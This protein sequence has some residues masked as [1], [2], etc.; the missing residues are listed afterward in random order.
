MG[1]VTGLFGKLAG[2]LV[3]K[4]VGGFFQAY[5]MWIIIAGL[6]ALLTTITIY[7]HGAEKAKA[8]VPV[9]LEEI[10]EFSEKFAQNE[11][12]MQECLDANQFNALEAKRQAGLVKKSEENVNALKEEMDTRVG[13]IKDEMELQRGRDKECR[14]VDDA[15]PAWF[16]AGLRE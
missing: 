9:L 2:T 10:K 6:V 14:T 3:G 13:D 7:V 11:L 4:A 8:R 16:V 12:A 5:G 15:L 1:I